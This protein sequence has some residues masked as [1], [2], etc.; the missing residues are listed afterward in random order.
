MTRRTNLTNPD[1]PRL[2]ASLG[3]T[4]KSLARRTGAASPALVSSMSHPKSSRSPTASLRTRH[5]RLPYPHPD[6]IP[7]PLRLATTKIP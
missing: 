2:V 7:Q 5:R 4:L 1:T 3:T 6:S